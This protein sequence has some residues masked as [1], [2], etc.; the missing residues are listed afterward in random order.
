M[1]K[2]K[3]KNT[4]PKKKPLPLSIEQVETAAPV[5]IGFTANDRHGK[6]QLPNRPIKIKSLEE[7]ENMFG[8]AW[9]TTLTVNV[10]DG[11]LKDSVIVPPLRYRMY[12]SLQLYFANGG[13]PCYVS[14]AGAYS[15][16][17]AQEAAHTALERALAATQKED[18]PT[19]ILIPDAHL[20]G[21]EGSYHLFKIALRQCA[22]LMDRVTIVDLYSPTG[23]DAF[24][25]IRASFQAHIGDDF[26]NYGAAYYPYLRTLFDQAIDEATQKVRVGKDTFVMRVPDDSD[27]SALAASLF[28]Q[29]GQLYADIKDSWASPSNKVLLPPSPAVAGVYCRTDIDYGVW[30]APA[31]VRLAS[32][33]DLLVNIDD[34]EQ[35]AMTEG[36]AVNAIRTFPGRG[37]LVWGARTLAGNDADGRYISVRRYCIMVEKSIKRAIEPFAYEPNDIDTWTKV[38]ALIENFLVPQWQKGALKGNRPSEAFFVGL[39]LGRTMTTQDIVEKRMVVQIGLAILRPTEFIFLNITLDMVGP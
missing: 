29:H 8:G 15:R 33:T 27:P 25:K 4:D 3:K 19:I 37:T 28:H 9:P 24:S 18:G 16:A 2:R 5:F 36:K 14:S 12:Y 35:E 31:N 32:I 17:M 11:K 39:G 1:T 20:A 38:I 7:Y 10:A 26:L 21:E 34:R 6:A 23:K 30:K 22:L 13:G